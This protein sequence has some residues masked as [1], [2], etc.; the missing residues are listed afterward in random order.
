MTQSVSPSFP[1]G[2]AEREGLYDPRFEHDACGVG[3]VAH[4]RGE[5]SHR[6]VE[7]ALAL[8]ERLSHRSAVGGDA[9][10]GDGAG[11]LLH[12]PHAFFRRTCREL[13]MSLPDASGYGVGMVFLSREPDL[14]TATE[15]AIE[16]AVIEHGFRTLGWRD[17]PVRLEHAGE[18]A[19][20]SCPA[21]RQL[22]VAP[23]GVESDVAD[24]SAFERSLYVLRKRIERSTVI[25]GK[26]TCYV[27]SLSSR[28]IVYKG[29]LRP[30]KLAAFYI[31]LGEAEVESGLALVHSRF[32]TNTFPSWSLAHPYRFICHNGEINT[33]RGNVGWMCVRQEA[34]SSD[35]FGHDL[36]LLE[37]VI[38]SSQSDSASLDNAI[39]LLIHAGRP[40]AH[41]LM[42]LVPE[43]WERHATMPA[44]RRGF[45]EYHASLVE[46]WDGPAAVAFT[47]GR[48]VG[49]VLDRNGLRPARYLVTDDDL[50]V[51]ASETGAFAVEAEHVQKRGRLAPGEML[52]VNTTQGVLLED[53]QVKDE[54]ASLR[55]YR[56]WVNEQR[57]TMPD[58]PVPVVSPAPA[59]L[60]VRQ[61]EFGYTRE[62]LR[63]VLAPM[64][65]NGEEPIGSMG[66]DTPL[67]VLSE[68]PQH[69]SA[70]FRQ[71]FA[72]VTN[73]AI[74]PIREQLVMSL[75]MYLGPQRNLLDETPEHAR[76]LRL[77]HPVLTAAAMQQL[78]ALDVEGMRTTTLDARFPAAGGPRALEHWLE[79]LCSAAIDAASTGS[80][81]I[82]LS[83]R[84]VNA[85]WA[86][87]PSLLAVSAVHHALIRARVRS[88]V[89]LVVE[90]DE[91]REVTHVAQ[92]FAYGASAVHPALALETVAELARTRSSGETT[93]PAAAQAHYVKAVEKGLLK[94]LSKMGISTLQSYCGAQLWEA[95]G[96]SSSLIERH[97]TGTT[98]P[99]SG[100][101][102]EA[103]A[104]ETLR[105]HTAAFDERELDALLDAGGDY[106]HRLHGEH[107]AWN[108][109]AIASLQHAARSDD[110]SS[111]EK[112][113]QRVN[114]DTRRTTLRGLLD[115][116]ERE[117][118]PIHEVEPPSA[119]VRRFATG[120]MSFGSISREAHET[121]AIAMNRIGGRSNTG[122]G[123]EDPA[124]FGTERNSAIKQ[125]ASAR[126]GVT[127][128]YLVSASE[129][130]IKIA[131]G[132]K[133]GEGGQL[134]G[135][136][137][138]E[139]IAR[140]RHSTPGVTLISPPPHHDIYSIEDLKQLIYD[141][142]QVSPSATIS[143]KLVAEAGVGTVA[144][145]VAKAAAD[146]I[147][148][149]GDS[150]GTGASPLSSIKRAGTP[151]ELGLAETQQ[152][153]VL[154]GLR[155][156]VRLQTD[157]QLKTG[158]DVVIAALLGAEEFG[159][160]T[161][162]LIVSGCVMMRKC[163]LNT[164]PVGIA[165]QDPE[166]RAKFTGKPEHVVNYFFLV[167]EEVRDLMARLG[168]RTMDEMIGRADVLRQSALD[169]HWKA[170]TLDLSRVLHVPGTLDERATRRFT[171]VRDRVATPAPAEALDRVI[172]AAALPAIE[173]G[174]Q[175]RVEL[176]I[177]NVN[178]AVG[179][180][181]AGHIARRQGSAGLP[182]DSIVLHFRGS[183]GQS[184]GA[185]AVNGMSLELEGE[186]NDYV[187]KGLSGG[188]IVIRP[189]RTSRLVPDGTIIV[190]NTTLYGAT[191]G[192]AFIAGGAGER[193]AVRN[194]GATAVIEGVGDHGCEYMTGGTVVVLGRTG[195]NF[196]AGMSGGTAFVLDERQELATQCGPAALELTHLADP[197]ELSMLRKLV[198]RHAK[199]TG[200]PRARHVLSHWDQL[201]R[202][203]VRVMPAE[204]RQALERRAASA[205][206]AKIG[207][208]QK[209]EAPRYG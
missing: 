69:L 129:L 153:L 85:S 113:S 30:T 190:G 104:T 70:Y 181:L 38:G 19:R 151:W 167:A 126:F 90:T 10:T 77:D 76:Q 108:P 152:T 79:W 142:R 195:R 82:V 192:E 99:V 11:I 68:R 9:N 173:R 73:P 158:R 187:G 96:L 176:P 41:A 109:L 32:S 55:P 53:A 88:R 188:R 193:F 66:N 56:R 52:L 135:H 23:G 202:Q 3:F 36:A 148:I 18:S 47:D 25:D 134:P 5:R 180:R 17:V 45:Y 154:N 57:L 143:V 50:V 174:E 194:S 29:L 163:H 8:L 97:F 121:L 64:A 13:G 123:G 84:D 51:L 178:R 74:D 137:V 206:S 116:T 205:G 149:S 155:G 184:F 4:L 35:R 21:I 7:S 200:S 131:Q 164:C 119:I 182:D 40:L 65:A 49:A 34:M 191:S 94:V 105:R 46:P 132:A 22:F 111:Y 107:H 140:T 150:G 31:D 16:R 208:R 72:Q 101:D 91:A 89:S 166:L 92:L 198:E 14:R 141:L 125:V 165:T 6:I 54:I 112:F 42:M 110:P 168:F 80:T 172:L 209:G 24:A 95:V 162:P 122:E 67:A 62:E 100:I 169:D 170:R 98:S 39:E 133:P 20:E 15:H 186:A 78:R 115:F 75:T 59:S 199:F 12:L 144:A 197:K 204:Y 159:F 177:T 58:V 179:A 117:P 86:P 28:T 139:I 124:R 201:V 103:I 196:A 161:A 61:R 33:V 145:G 175:L 114:E 160:A 207:G 44:E 120:A 87:I 102:L 83:D 60:R 156:R 93:D 71:Q 1:L 130:Q 37:P 147:V 81:I 146:L 157:G 26:P 63:M 128:E 185:F 127:T 2:A 138:D 27:A 48:H 136:K 118:V 43:A 171:R 106:H 183:A 203:F 189:I